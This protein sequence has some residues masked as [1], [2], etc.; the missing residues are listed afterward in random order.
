MAGETRVGLLI[1]S[2][3]LL[4]QNTKTITHQF[5]A[6]LLATN[7]TNQS[8]PPSRRTF[9]PI[10]FYVGSIFLVLG[11]AAESNELL[12]SG[13]HPLTVAYFF[14]QDVAILISPLAIALHIYVVTRS[15]ILC[16]DEWAIRMHG[17]EDTSLSQPASEVVDTPRPPPDVADVCGRVSQLESYRHNR[18]KTQQESQTRLLGQL[19]ARVS[20]S[21]LVTRQNTLLLL[22]ALFALE[23]AVFAILHVVSTSKAV[24]AA[25]LPSGTTVIRVLFIQI[26][27]LLVP[28]QLSIHMSILDNLAS[29]QSFADITGYLGSAPKLWM[30]TQTIML[31]PSLLTPLALSSASLWAVGAFLDKENQAMTMPWKNGFERYGTC[32]DGLHS[33][34][35]QFIDCGPPDSSCPHTCREKYGEYLVIPGTRECSEIDGYAHITTQRACTV[36]YRTWALAHNRSTTLSAQVYAGANENYLF[37]KW[38]R[39]MWKEE[40]AMADVGFRCGAYPLPLIQFAFGPVTRYAFPALFWPLT[41]PGN[42]FKPLAYLCYSG[43][44]RESCAADTDN[45]AFEEMMACPAREEPASDSGLVPWREISGPLAQK[46]HA[47]RNKTHLVE[48]SAENYCA[49]IKVNEV[50]ARSGAQVVFAMSCAPVTDVPCPKN[51]IVKLSVESGGAASVRGTLFVS[52]TPN[53][54]MTAFDVHELEVVDSKEMTVEPESTLMLVVD[55]SASLPLN[56]KLCYDA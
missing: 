25:A 6:R 19:R 45:K 11:E 4:D 50:A 53:M 12:A 56:V 20:L 48:F 41:K 38:E 39:A 26:L 52:T 7:Q 37:G 10:L 5:T 51:N 40:D 28:F 15:M 33:G 21:A 49:K 42:T 27:P 23:A 9:L 34:R 55:W 47:L 2:L 35:E 8:T 31:T 32:A 13:V 17:D 29:Q 44:G 54:N 30:L 3:L 16:Y 36:G 14:I 22:P 18:A 24:E 1:A 46:T 43:N